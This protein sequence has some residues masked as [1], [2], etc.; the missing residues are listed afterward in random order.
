MYKIKNLKA[1]QVSEEPSVRDPQI[2]Y[3]LMVTLPYY[4]ALQI[5][6]IHHQ[7]KFNAYFSFKTLCSKSICKDNI[8]LGHWLWL[9]TCVSIPVV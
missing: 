5:Y 7:I 1:I 3:C 6:N 8:L 4:K 9:H 2:S